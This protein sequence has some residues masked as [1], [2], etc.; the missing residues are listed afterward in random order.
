MLTNMS[1]LAVMKKMSTE[2][3]IECNCIPPRQ[4]PKELL[5]TL[6]DPDTYF[7]KHRIEYIGVDEEGNPVFL[8]TR[9]GSLLW[10]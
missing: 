9:C 3:P 4:V 6:P 8:C 10:G 7:K 2:K 5:D 1:N